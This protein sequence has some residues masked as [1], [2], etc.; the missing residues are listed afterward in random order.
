MALLKPKYQIVEE[1]IMTALTCV[2]KFMNMEEFNGYK[3][4]Y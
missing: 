1:I 2:L 3:K 4:S